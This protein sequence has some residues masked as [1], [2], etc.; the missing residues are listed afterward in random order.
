MSEDLKRL[1]PQS[2][3]AEKGLLGSALLVPHEVVSKA[4]EM[5]ITH[6]S[7]HIPAHS[8]IWKAMV[9]IVTQ[10]EIPLDIII[11]T[12]YLRDKGSLDE[13]GGAALVSSLFTFVPT[14]VNFPLYAET[15]Q[16]KET[17]RAIIATCTK[18]REMA[19]SNQE[20]LPDIVEGLES[21]AIKIVRQRYQ[22]TDICLTNEIIKN[23]NQEINSIEAGE[24][25]SITSGFD[26]WDEI[27]HGIIARRFYAIGARPKTGKTALIEQMADAQASQKIPVAIFQQDMS[28]GDMMGRI[29]CRKSGIVFDD[30]ICG[31]LTQEQYISV[32]L[33]LEEIDQKYLRIFS[34]HNLTAQELAVIIKREVKENG[35]K[36]FYL[37]L[38]QR[39]KTGEKDR[40]EGLTDAANIIR[41]VIQ[42]TGVSGIILAEILKEA[43]T[44][45]RP[46]SGQFKY[47]DGLFSS[48]DTSIMLW[49]KDDPKEIVKGSNPDRRQEII[50][51]IDANRGG[52]VSD[53]KI[54]FDRPNMQ[55]YSTPD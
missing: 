53:N 37:D 49:T 30:Y 42:T 36:V 17:L 26:S 11:L 7:F 2:P 1:L 50:F 34:P 40:V 47:C 38:F 54:Y 39:L 4:T 44:T 10:K 22:S 3:D 5:G 28:V 8:I 16:E 24:E 35:I 48:C 29:A 46:H 9:D 12:Q 52:G 51:T 19:Y 27:L 15:I 21:D 18:H 25:I 13:A 43:D 41:D 32:R 55:F 45:K 31:R 33:A 14:A 23:M 6:K 20:D